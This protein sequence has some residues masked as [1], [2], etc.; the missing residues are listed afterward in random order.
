MITDQTVEALYR[1]AQ[2][3]EDNT[4]MMNEFILALA[5]DGGEDNQITMK[6][7]SE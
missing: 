1:I 4:A 7:L 5:D 3:I 2:A 6:Y